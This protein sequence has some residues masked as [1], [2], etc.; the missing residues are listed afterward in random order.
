MKKITGLLL[1]LLLAISLL[2]CSK[3]EAQ[4]IE[5]ASFDVD[6]SGYESM[7]STNHHFRGI[8]PEEF[9]RVYEED[10]SGIFYIGYTGCPN[11]QA[12][13]PTI[14][15]AAIETDSTVYYLDPYSEDYDF[16]SYLDDIMA[17]LDPILRHDS[18][19]TAT[20]YTPHIFT[21]INGEFG[22]SYIGGNETL[23]DLVSLMEEVK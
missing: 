3:E 6:M 8:T 4:F 11:C 21:L 10:G 18:D 7:P 5:I 20:I 17:T 16:F 13:V 15:E 1:T 22:T 19:G 14:E 2:G 9:M 23:E 12:M